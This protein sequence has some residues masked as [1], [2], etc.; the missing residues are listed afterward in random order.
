VYH[1]GRDRVKLC[2]AHEYA[3]YTPERRKDAARPLPAEICGGK[4][5]DGGPARTAREAAGPA[6]AS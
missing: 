6:A 2:N 4:A 1:P 5:D 3:R